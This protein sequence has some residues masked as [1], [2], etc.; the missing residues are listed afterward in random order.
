MKSGRFAPST[1]LLISLVAG[2][3]SFFLITGRISAAPSVF[4]WDANS[5]PLGS[6]SE[7]YTGIGQPASVLTFTF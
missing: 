7:I 6:L 4:D 1:F 3:L 2:G 5:W